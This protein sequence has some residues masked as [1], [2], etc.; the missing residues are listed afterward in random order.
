MSGRTAHDGGDGVLTIGSCAA[1]CHESGQVRKEAALSGLSRVLQGRLVR[2][3]G[4]RRRRQPC[5]DGGVTI[6]MRAFGRRI[7]YLAF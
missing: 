5:L 2:A 1:G 4:F 7:W 3:Y 6:S